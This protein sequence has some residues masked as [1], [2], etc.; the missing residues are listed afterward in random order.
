MRYTCVDPRT[1]E[2]CGTEHRTREA[3][4]RH[5]GARRSIRVLR[6]PAEQ[7]DEDAQYRAFLKFFAEGAARTMGA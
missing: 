2:T 5:T 6:T 4:E 1:N 7:A 3:C